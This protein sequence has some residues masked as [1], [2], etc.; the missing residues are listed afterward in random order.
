MI[1]AL[2]LALLLAFSVSHA[3]EEDP[4]RKLAKARMDEREVLSTLGDL[5]KEMAKMAENQMMYTAA[6]RMLQHQFRLM[7]TAV[8]EGR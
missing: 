4:S 5:D 3:Q 1:R 7:K 6:I 8:S 2:V